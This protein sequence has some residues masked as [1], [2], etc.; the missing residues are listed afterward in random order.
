MR[1]LVLAAAAGCA[2]LAWA[3]PASATSNRV[4]LQGTVLVKH[5]DVFRQDLAE[6]WYTL[7]TK[8]GHVKLSFRGQGPTYLGGAR[9]VVHGTRAKGMVR[10]P[11]GGV[12]VLSSGHKTAAR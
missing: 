9:V 12:R 1:L 2:I 7:K 6:Y 3:G 11:D 8:R 5:A 10:V 4:T